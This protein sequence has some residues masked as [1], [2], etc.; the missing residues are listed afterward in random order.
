MM[1]IGIKIKNINQR[2]LEGAVT[3]V[4][5]AMHRRVLRV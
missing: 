1:V 5:V 3:A 2:R 4:A